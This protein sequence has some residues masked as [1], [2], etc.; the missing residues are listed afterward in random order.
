MIWNPFKANE[1]IKL[2]EIELELSKRHG[3]SSCTDILYK[4]SKT[5][6]YEKENKNLK[7]I[8]ELKE[9]VEKLYQEKMELY[10][11]NDRLAQKLKDSSTIEV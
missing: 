5:T 6:F 8:E 10:E 9:R 3:C 4:L 1:K 7:L 11:H 2:L